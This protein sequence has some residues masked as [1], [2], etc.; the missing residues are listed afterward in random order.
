M[1]TFTWLCAFA[2]AL[3]STPRPAEADVGSCYSPRP[4]CIGTQPVCLCSYTQ[5]C[6][7]SCQ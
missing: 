2:V 1:K 3:A 6:F 5:Q 7:W 4:I